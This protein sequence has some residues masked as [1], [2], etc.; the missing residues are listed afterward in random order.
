MLYK[1][2]FLNWTDGTY[3]REHARRKIYTLDTQVVDP[4]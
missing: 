2:Q 3:S 4:G 1:G